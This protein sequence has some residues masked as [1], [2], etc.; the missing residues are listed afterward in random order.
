MR[1]RRY[2]VRMNIPLERFERYI[3][4]LPADVCWPWGASLDE[5]G[6]GRYEPWGYGI[7]KKAHRVAYELAFGP[8]P[9][10]FHVH[11]T[12]GTK[13]CV[14]PAHLTALSP[15]THAALGRCDFG[16]RNRCKTHCPQGH[17]YTEA[18]TRTRDG[19][20]HCKECDRARWKPG[21]RTHIAPANRDK[22]HCPAGHEYTPGNTR[23]KNGARHCRSCNNERS[24]MLR[25]RTRESE[26]H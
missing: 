16:E 17:E 24:R 2:T 10:G 21:S 11:H 3:P 19:K 25:Q 6:Y 22:T 15:E 12:C 1:T 26:H 18:N 23:A 4:S 9:E 20:R 14:N 8:I 7:R 5:G 13:S